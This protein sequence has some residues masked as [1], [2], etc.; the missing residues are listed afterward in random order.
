MVVEDGHRIFNPAYVFFGN[1]YK[2]IENRGAYMSRVRKILRPGGRVAIVGFRP[3]G[4]L[5]G[6]PEEVRLSQEQVIEEVEQAGFLLTETH[7]FLPRQ[8]LLVFEPTGRL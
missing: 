1:V 8:Y 6:P 2:E 4:S 7:D 5:A 3:G